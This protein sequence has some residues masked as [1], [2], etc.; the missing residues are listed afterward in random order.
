MRIAFTASSALIVDARGRVTRLVGR[1]RANSG[2]L[3]FRVS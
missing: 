1:A 3:T 2:A